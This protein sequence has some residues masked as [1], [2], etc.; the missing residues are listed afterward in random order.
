MA[1]CLIL[2][3]NVSRLVPNNSPVKKVVEDAM[4]K[5]GNFI[6]EGEILQ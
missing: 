1:K 4:E 3:A 5:S 6:Q 2:A